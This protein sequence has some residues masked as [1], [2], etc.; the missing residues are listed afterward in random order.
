MNG[1]F[2]QSELAA[3]EALEVVRSRK[4]ASLDG[5]ICSFP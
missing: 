2:H 1:D 4:H 3:E 5:V